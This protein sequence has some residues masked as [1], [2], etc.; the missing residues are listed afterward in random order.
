MVLGYAITS[1]RNPI[2]KSTFDAAKTAIAAAA[3]KPLP[4]FVSLHGKAQSLN[5]YVFAHVWYQTAMS[6]PDRDVVTQAERLVSKYVWHPARMQWIGRDTLVRPVYQGGLGIHSIEQR[7]RA[8]QLM[9]IV[10]YWKACELPE[11]ERPCWYRTF[12][13]QYELSAVDIHAQILMPFYSALRRLATTFRWYRDGDS[14]CMLN[15]RFLLSKISIAG[16]SACLL[17]QSEPQSLVQRRQRWTMLLG[18]VPPLSR[19]AW[20]TIALLAS[21]NYFEPKVRDFRYRLL[22]LANG[23][24]AKLADRNLLQSPIC[25][26]C[27]NADEDEYHIVWECNDAQRLW[28]LVAAIVYDILGAQVTITPSMACLGPFQ[29]RPYRA[30]RLINCVMAYASYSLYVSH[31]Q[32]L[33]SGNSNP[34][35]TFWANLER[36]LLWKFVTVPLPQFRSQFCINS[37]LC[38]VDPDGF[39][40]LIT[41]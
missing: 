15:S 38:E 27:G 41:T 21:S 12:A 33:S 31:K 6:L 1:A 2:D 25:R 32:H 22:H 34:L 20:H 3:D 11:S 7:A 4:S 37:V 8:Q 24:A 10:R 5:R 16:I 14:V 17:E 28:A 40:L 29:I 30:Q 9:W 26:L 35:R 39:I 18:V 36:H 19:N 13:F 23:T